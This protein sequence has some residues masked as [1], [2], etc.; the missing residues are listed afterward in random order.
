MC[1][2]T[3]T[4]NNYYPAVTDWGQYLPKLEVFSASASG[5]AI[6]KTSNLAIGSH[7]EQQLR[8]GPTYSNNPE[9]WELARP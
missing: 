9:R 8:F 7:F 3:H 1:V 6:T 2:Y 5:V 4:A